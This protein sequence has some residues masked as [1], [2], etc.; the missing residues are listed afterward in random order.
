MS[1]IAAPWP[2]RHHAGR[3]PPVLILTG[4]QDVRTGRN[5]ANDNIGGIDE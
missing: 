4:L 5:D 1:S 3:I 2:P